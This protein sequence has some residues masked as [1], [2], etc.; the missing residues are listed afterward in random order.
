MRVHHI[1]SDSKDKTVERLHGYSF[2]SFHNKIKITHAIQR[3]ITASQTARASATSVLLPGNV[4]PDLTYYAHAPPPW[5]EVTRR[6]TPDILTAL[7]QRLSRGGY[8][9]HPIPL[10][11]NMHFSL[12]KMNPTDASP[13]HGFDDAIL[14][15]YYALKHLG[16]ETEIR[17][18]SVNDRSRNIVFGSCIAPR[19]I[20]R[21]L[22][23]GSIIFNLEQAN[24]ASKWCNRDYLTHLKDFT[25][26]DYSAE[27]VRLLAA[28]GV[29][30]A[31]HVPLGYVPEMTRLAPG[32]PEDVDLLFYGLVTERRD[33]VLRRLVAEG[34]KVIASQEAFGDLRDSLLAHARVVL[35]VHQFVPARLEVV[36]LGYVW[37]NKKAVLSERGP[38]TEVP[39][40]LEEACV[41]AEYDGLVEA[42]ARLL[43]EPD[44]AARQAERGF[45]AF[46][47]RP[48]TVAL[49]KIVGRRVRPAG[50]PGV[51]ES[52]T[53][54]TSADEAGPDRARAVYARPER[55]WLITAG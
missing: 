31:V 10:L 45:R 13:S 6:I 29:P 55:E 36:R 46:A 25:V 24:G 32:Y 14:P 42:A 19:R 34:H 17:F 22:P 20:G 26:W 12:I 1:N 9:S 5:F 54:E 35:N 16:F 41:W 21:A 48:M 49:E 47:A 39:D 28:M 23:R 38:E 40:H 33:A 2:Y 44:A 3:L 50:A 11:A 53:D 37:A 18:N 8:I 27:N 52:G 7:R 30:D 43:A 15:L 4:L 51:H